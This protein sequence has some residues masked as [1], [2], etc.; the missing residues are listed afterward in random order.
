MHYFPKKKLQNVQNPGIIPSF[1][2]HLTIVSMSAK[3]GHH[4]IGA[5][6]EIGQNRIRGGW[7]VKK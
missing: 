4:K 6:A 7:G 3:K 1:Y 5:C 2:G